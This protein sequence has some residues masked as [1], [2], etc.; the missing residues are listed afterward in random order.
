VRNRSM[1]ISTS[2]RTKGAMMPGDC[3]MPFG[4]CAFVAI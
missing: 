1:P 2:P 3:A 4:L